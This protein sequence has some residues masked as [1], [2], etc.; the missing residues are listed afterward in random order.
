MAPA[1]KSAMALTTRAETGALCLTAQ[2]SKL[3]YANKTERQG[4]PGV[5]VNPAPEVVVAGK[6]KQ[7]LYAPRRSLEGG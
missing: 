4:S 3:L 1:L 6:D 5:A 7:C 2:N